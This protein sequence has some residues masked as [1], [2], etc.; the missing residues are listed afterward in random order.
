MGDHIR[1]Q[2][3]ID[4]IDQ[5][6]RDVQYD[7]ENIRA[8]DLDHQSN[9]KFEIY[10]A[11]VGKTL[12]GGISNA[13]HLDYEEIAGGSLKFSGYSDFTA[14]G[15]GPVDNEV[16]VQGRAFYIEAQD[17]DEDDFDNGIDWSAGGDA[18]INNITSMPT[19]T[20]GQNIID[21]GGYLLQFIKHTGYQPKVEGEGP[22]DLELGDKTT[23]WLRIVFWADLKA[24]T[25]CKLPPGGAI[26]LPMTEHEEHLLGDNYPHNGELGIVSTG[27]DRIAVEYLNVFGGSS[28][29][30]ID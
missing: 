13:T 4:V 5:I 24:Y 28:S 17:D 21:N 29:T 14:N 3:N 30:H 23:D 2:V 27:S 12:S 18:L 7:D 9:E 22:E 11:A 25:L 16:G 19:S 10:H 20:P 6:T 15:V 8:V 26:V 1:Y